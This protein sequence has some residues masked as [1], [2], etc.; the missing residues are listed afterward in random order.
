VKPV[1]HFLLD[2]HDRDIKLWVEGDRLRCS[3]PKGVLTPDVKAQLTA[4]KTDILSL[5]KHQ[6]DSQVT[7]VA[8][9]QEAIL[10]AAIH[11][12]S[13][14]P[15][16]FNQEPS[17]ILLTGATGFLGAF[18]LHELLQNTQAEIHCLVRANNADAGRQKI[19]RHLE[20]YLLWD[21]QLSSRI[22][23]IPGDL[24]QP[25]LGLTESQFE[26]IA[27]AIEVI[28]HN[29]ALVNLAYPYSALKA[30]N[31]LGTQEVLRL[32]VRHTLKPV[33]F[34]STVSVIDAV[35]ESDDPIMETDPIE[36]WQGLY[37]GYA[38]SKWVAEKLVSI[39]NARGIPVS[40][41][42]PGA[43]TGHSQTGVANTKD[44]LSTLLK[45]FIQLKTAPDLD[46]LWMLTPVDY[47]SRAVIH[48][49][50]QEASRG[51]TFH[52]INPYPLPMKTFVDWVRSFG[53]TLE[54]IPYAQWRTDLMDLIHR[55]QNSALKSLLPLFPEQFS[56][57][58]QQQLK[59]RFDCQNALNGLA[60]TSIQC[61]PTTA[62]LISTYLSYFIQHEF[63]DPPYSE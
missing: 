52:L 56:E 12:R 21:E 5:L 57:R 31:V 9:D 51:K 60:G 53:Y 59:L 3:A 17:R 27:H 44:F 47:V 54:Q 25:L 13:A 46:A 33:H 62:E 55:D 11:P 28:Y 63:F 38:Q 61:Q 35:P 58:Q 26:A 39:A 2:L 42:R 45:G 24:S 29:G 18:L 1:E 6:S 20:G 23:P 30:A 32:A 19:R 4:Y 48:L 14:T 16:E 37:N 10:D 15:L 41:Y 43:I 34:I 36:S 50:R 22:I 40:I 49:S 7:R 8:L